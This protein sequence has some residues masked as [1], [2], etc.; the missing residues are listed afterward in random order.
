MRL[1]NLIDNCGQLLNIILKSPNSSDRTAEF[2]FYDKRKII[3]SKERKFISEIVFT[4]IRNLLL[5][6]NISTT[7]NI[8]KHI[9]HPN[10]F[11][12]GKKYSLMILIQILLVEHFRLEFDFITINNIKYIENEKTLSIINSICLDLSAI[13]KTNNNS[14]KN[15]FD[16]INFDKI[17]SDKINFDNIINYIENELSQNIIEY[18][19]NINKKY[20][21]DNIINSL[22]NI[23]SFPKEFINNLLLHSDV[24]NIDNI[25]DFVKAMNRPAN[26]CIRVNTSITNVNDVINNLKEQGIE[27]YAG[28]ISP[29]CVII[30]TRRQLTTLDIYKQGYF[31]IQDEASQL[32]GFC[33][34]PQPNDT[35]LDACAGAGGKSLHLADM[36]NDNGS[37]IATDIESKKLKEII[38]RAALTNYKSITIATNKNDNI[39]LNNKSKLENKKFDIVL[40]DAPCSGA[41]TIR[42]DPMKKYT[43]LTKTINKISKNQLSILTNYSKYV[44]SNGTLIYSTCSIFPQE[45]ENI[46]KQ[47]LEENTD[48]IPEP[49]FPHL[50]KYGINISTLTE[51][52][53]Y[54]T[55]FPFIHNTDGFFIARMRRL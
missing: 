52:D 12:K 41:G 32:V 29:S 21:K 54:I 6:K 40:V 7:L 11:I 49:L 31:T 18:Y 33:I 36:Q 19:S 4:A 50:K 15:S 2:F 13:S 55:L 28:N 37:I 43:I 17:N 53:F 27:S 24:I 30:P 25:L 9:N 3:G 26:T 5:L 34:N 10:I 46:V 16:K 20:N 35:I 22:E 14:D 23:Y 51:K 45:N 48:F 42:R 1:I 8:E 47:F 38:K 44:K 39:I